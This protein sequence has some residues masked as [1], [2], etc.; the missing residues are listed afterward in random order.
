M[1]SKSPPFFIPEAKAHKFKRNGAWK[2]ADRIHC[3][4]MI[5]F[6]PRTFAD[7]ITRRR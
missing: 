6:Q 4:H 3:M 1:L 7:M 5:Y 2:A